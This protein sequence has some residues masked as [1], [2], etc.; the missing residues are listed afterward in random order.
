MEITEGL[1]GEA[2][3]LV[4]SSNTARTMGSGDME[5]FATPSM[6]ALMEKAATN[7]LKEYLAS[8]SSSVGTVISVR[9]TA[10]TPL[11]MTVTARAVLT[12]VDGKR[13]V[14]SVEAFDEK[15]KIG[16]GTHERFIVNRERFLTK[17]NGKK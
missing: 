12:G 3:A 17:A 11:G 10:A 1:T 2:S 5:V 7:A 6:I 8:D 9:H 13:L 15:D 4:D 16:E 14:F